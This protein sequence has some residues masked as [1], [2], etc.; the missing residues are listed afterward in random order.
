M[1]DSQVLVLS[2]ESEA[3]KYSENS[4]KQEAEFAPNA[5][6]RSR[7]GIFLPKKA[8]LAEA[9]Y[10][11]FLFSLGPTHGSNKGEINFSTCANDRRIRSTLKGIHS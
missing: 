5:W 3:I 8:V 7:F 4:A 1:R 6:G 9:N 10:G 11:P 2:S